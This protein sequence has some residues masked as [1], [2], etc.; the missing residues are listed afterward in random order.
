MSAYEKFK[1]ILPYAFEGLDGQEFVKI[2]VKK[3]LTTEEETLPDR[4]TDTIDMLTANA[5]RAETLGDVRSNIHYAIQQLRTL[6]DN[7]RK[8]PSD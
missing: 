8:F 2:N 4:F 6:H 7:L 1:E 3:Y 5:L